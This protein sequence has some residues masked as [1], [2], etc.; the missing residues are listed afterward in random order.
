MSCDVFAESQ[1]ILPAISAA[2]SCRHFS[3]SLW[4]SQPPKLI[5]AQIHGKG[6]CCKFSEHVIL[7][8]NRGELSQEKCIIKLNFIGRT[9]KYYTSTV[10]DFAIWYR[11]KAWLNKCI[12][13][14]MRGTVQSSPNRT[15]FQCWRLAQNLACSFFLCCEEWVFLF[16]VKIGWWQI[17]AQV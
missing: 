16:P 15:D 17:Q 11:G 14:W 4:N 3:A 9:V 10:D 2:K 8:S 6:S 12:I 5:H 1:P 7:I 13:D